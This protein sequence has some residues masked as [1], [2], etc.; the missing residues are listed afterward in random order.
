MTDELGCKDTAIRIVPVYHGPLVP[1]AF[2]PNLD[3]NNDFL[4]ILGG[5]FS[6]VEFTIFN[7]W[8]E[9]VYETTEVDAVGWDGT[10]KNEPQPLG[11]Y[12][13]VAKVV[14]FDG[15]EHVLS[16]DVSLIR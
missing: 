5:N 2:S 14:T 13:Y 6:A 3:G 4:M 9:V 15:Q 8:G 10:Y 7:N 16:G 1:S 11:V 12:V